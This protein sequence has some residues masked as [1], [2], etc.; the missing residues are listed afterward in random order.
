MGKKKSVVLIVLISIVMFVLAVIT[1]FPKFTIPGTNGV[2]EWNPAVLQYDLG[3]DFGGGYYAYYYPQGVITEAEYKENVKALTGDELT[4]YEKSYKQ[5]GTTSLYLSTDANDGIFTEGNQ[6]EVSVAFKTAFAKAVDLVAERFEARA[7]KSGSSYSVSVVDDYA[8]RVELSAG[9]DSKDMSSSE[10][11]SQA[12][13]LFSLTDKLYFMQGEEVVSQ[14]VDEG[15]SVSDLI[16][17]VSVRTKYE[18]AQLQITFTDKGKEMLESFKSAAKENSSTTLNLTVGAGAD[19][20]TLLQITSDVINTK[21]EVQYG[22][23]YEE[24]K[25]YAETLCIF[26]QS[27]MENGGIYLNDNETTPFAFAALSSSSVRVYSAIEGE[28]FVG[29]IIAVFALIVL[30][31]AYA[32]VKMGG[33]GVVNLYTTVSYFLIAA[34]CF[35]FISGGSFIVSY[36]SILVFIIGLAL[37]NVLNAYIYNA[38]KNET[39]LGK[40]IGSSVK[41][42]YS[43]TLLPIVD[44]YAVLLLG[45]LA[46][47]IGTTGLATVA[48]QAIICV[49]AGAFCNL[50]W[51]RMLNVLFLSASKDKYKYFRLVR[52]DEDDE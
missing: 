7:A 32:I 24:E 39:A 14:L 1:A 51:G 45:A 25:L 13:S 29:V 11:A 3:S 12:F 27:A 40:T 4:E 8:I 22:V 38:I 5:H 33:F 47:L 42:G 2:K 36:A 37:T 41:N 28:V 26:I 30:A 20:T 46:L 6:E 35:A 9:E 34:L 19:K 18:V 50:A 10:Y 17:S 44:I 48:V 31:A 23:R 43:K 15:S 52:E 16:K 49:V 21:N